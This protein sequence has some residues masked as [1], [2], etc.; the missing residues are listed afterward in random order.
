M[1]PLHIIN[2]IKDFNRI[3]QIDFQN[4]IQALSEN[5]WETGGSIKYLGGDSSHD[6]FFNQRLPLIYIDYY[7]EAQYLIHTLQDTNYNIFKSDAK[8][9]R[10]FSLIKK[11][12][13]KLY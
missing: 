12:V 6:E 9:S 11:W 10:A 8:S 4:G 1:I 5:I 7:E 3:S 13:L 2:L